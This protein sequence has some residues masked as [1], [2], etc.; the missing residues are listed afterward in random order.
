MTTPDPA[1]TF[2]APGV[3][4]TRP[5]TSPLEADEVIAPG[6]HTPALD[7]LVGELTAELAAEK[8]FPVPGRPGY[9]VTFDVDVDHTMLGLWRKAARDKDQP[10]AFDELKFACTI[11]AAQCIRIIRNG[12]PLELDGVEVTFRDRAFFTLLGTQSANSAV[13]KLYGRDAHIIATSTAILSAAG[14]GSDVDED[15]TPASSND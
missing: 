11:V 12:A 2:A 10:D 4:L 6:K 8:T 13:R 15:P 1:A 3:D 9:A 7:S 14:Y 5:P